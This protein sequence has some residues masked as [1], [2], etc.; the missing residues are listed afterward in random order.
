QHFNIEIGL[1]LRT[2]RWEGADYWLTNAVAGL[3]LQDMI[4]RADVATIGIDGGGL[5]DLLGLW[6]TFRDRDTRDWLVYARAWAHAKV[7]ER[8]EQ[9][10]PT[11]RDFEVEGTLTFYRTPG[12]DIAELVDIVMEVEEAGLLPEKEAIG[13]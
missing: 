6:I 12:E 11:L 2:D 8:H 4:A 7:I 10:A 13:V 5:N 1:A 3:T 9:I